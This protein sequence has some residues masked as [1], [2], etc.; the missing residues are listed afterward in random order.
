[1]TRVPAGR[2]EASADASRRELLR[3]LLLLGAGPAAGPT[4]VRLDRDACLAWRGVSCRSC[5]DRCAEAA[6]L[7]GPD[8]RVRLQ[9][10]ACTGCGDCTDACPVRALGRPGDR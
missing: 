10:A 4:P 3:R 8:G 5:L 6:L 9:A 2:V 7:S 1:V